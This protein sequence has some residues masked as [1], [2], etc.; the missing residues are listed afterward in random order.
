MIASSLPHIHHSRLAF[1][2]HILKR[3]PLLVSLCTLASSDYDSLSMTFR[4]DLSQA[5]YNIIVSY[6]ADLGGGNH[7]LDHLYQRRSHAR[8]DA[9]PT[10]LHLRS[11]FDD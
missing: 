10:H 2:N 6:A 5:E 4:Q 11:G 9:V 8:Q 7:A 3:S 1:C